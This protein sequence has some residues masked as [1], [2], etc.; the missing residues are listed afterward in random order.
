MTRSSRGLVLLV[1]VLAALL[2]GCSAP[3]GDLAERVCA[4]AGEQDPLCQRLRATAQHPRVG[5]VE[6]CKAGLAYIDELE[7]R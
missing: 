5:E 4:R 1:A 7:R 6:A 2:A 3:C